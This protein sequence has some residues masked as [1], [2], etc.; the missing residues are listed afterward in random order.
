[1]FATLANGEAI[2]YNVNGA[3]DLARAQILRV[4]LEDQE[5]ERIGSDGRHDCEILVH[6]EETLPTVAAAAE[7]AP[8]AARDDARNV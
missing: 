3:G 1:M 2:I 6:P 4:A 5:P 8:P 7:Q